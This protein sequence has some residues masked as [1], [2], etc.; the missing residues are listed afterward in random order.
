VKVRFLRRLSWIVFLFAFSLSLAGD[1]LG[2]GHKKV[3]HVFYNNP[4]S[5]PASNLIFDAQG[6]LYGST[7]HSGHQ[8][9]MCGTVF[10]LSPQAGGGWEY[11][12]LYQFKGNGDGGYPAGNL[13]F[14]DA[15]S[16]YGASDYGSGSIFRLTQHI[17]GSWTETIVYAFAGAPDGST[18]TGG[19]I[20]DSVG[21]FYGTT[22]IG[23]KYGEGTV[24]ELSPQPGGGWSEAVL[25]SFSGADGM[26]PEAGV[27]LDKNG[28]LYGATEFGGQYRSGTVFELAHSAGNWS[29]TVI[30]S[31]NGSV[32]D[33]GSPFAGVV[34]DS[35]GN[36]Y[37]TETGYS[38]RV[39]RLEPNLDGSWTETILHAFGKGDDGDF[40]WSNLVF[41]A[42]GNLYG[43]TYVGGTDYQGIIYK[44][45]PI[46][47]GRWKYTVFHSFNLADGANPT[48]NPVTFDASGNLFVATE[49]G[50]LRPSYGVVLEISP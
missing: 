19:L 5:N 43:T 46:Q 9:C 27:T 48:D 28:N 39:F 17:D 35:S 20:I 12:V 32:T 42:D 8:A 44:L 26:N 15:G 4:A 10:R 21:N 30:H 3:L 47:G 36:V 33:P 14:D 23:G 34:L 49:G 6:N 50:G 16:L 24:Y 11:Q 2:A 37:G 31:F 29:E 38:G 22:G 40:P 25:Y 1:A 45:A 41:D 13:V 18:P 7:V